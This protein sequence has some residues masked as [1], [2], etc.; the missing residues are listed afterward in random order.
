MSSHTEMQYF[1]KQ[2]KLVI[3]KIVISILHLVG[4]IGLYLPL[5]RSVFQGLTP[6]HLLIVTGLLLSFHNDFN[7]RFWLFA[8]F[9]FTVGMLS[10][11]IGVKTGLIFGDYTYGPVLGPQIFGVPLIIGINWF[12]LV[13][14]TGGI[15]S[16]LIKNDILAALLSS[17]LMVLMDMVLEP[18]AVKLDFWQWEQ[19]DIP[20]SNFA[21]WF[22]IAFII[23]ITYRKIKF[24]KKNPLNVFIFIN[25]ILFFFILA[26]ILE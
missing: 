10:E 5:S 18:V 23:Q 16:G 22:L 19:E 3:A 25:L 15:F 20:L 12:L 1:F 4:L 26:I 14:L 13:Y 11:I 8:L 17:T 24:K 7:L 2:N 21:G 9:A 6:L